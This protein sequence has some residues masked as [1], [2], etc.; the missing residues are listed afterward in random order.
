MRLYREADLSTLDG[1]KLSNLLDVEEVDLDIV[2]K[3]EIARRLDVAPTTV[4]YWRD[5]NGFPEPV[6]IASAVKAGPGSYPVWL[7]AD[8]V[9]WKET[10]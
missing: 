9:A 5:R 10:R 3:S 2:G 4:D 8:V 7:W 1:I 6:S